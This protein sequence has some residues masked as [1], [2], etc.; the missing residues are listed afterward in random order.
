MVYK[1]LI[2]SEVEF[3]SIYSASGVRDV[4]SIVDVADMHGIAYSIG[5]I[6]ECFSD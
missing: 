2:T 1:S 6:C 3:S 4:I 5:Q